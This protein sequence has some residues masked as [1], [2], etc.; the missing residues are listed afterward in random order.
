MKETTQHGLYVVALLQL[1]TP[2]RV[3]NSLITDRSDC[4]MVHGTCRSWLGY[5][6][7]EKWIALETADIADKD[8]CCECVANYAMPEMLASGWRDNCK[9]IT[10]NKWRHEWRRD[11][12]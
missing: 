3:L 4:S 1:F 7:Q 11:S 2:L 5:S 10:R 9:I 6:G 12:V 8:V